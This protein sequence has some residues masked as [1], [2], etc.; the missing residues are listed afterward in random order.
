MLL[1]AASASASV[2]DIDGTI[3]TTDI[4]TQVDGLDIQSFCIDGETLIALEDLEPYGFTVYYNDNIR[5]VFITKTGTPND[6]FLPSVSRGKV[7]GTAGYYYETDIN[8]VVNGRIIRAYAVDGKMAA[9]VEDLGNTGRFSD[10]SRYTYHMSFDYDNSKRLLSLNTSLSQFGT[11]DDAK[12]VILDYRLWQ[13]NYCRIQHSGDKLLAEKH[14]GGLPHGGSQHNYYVSL[15]NGLIYDAS[16]IA[17]MY[18]INMNEPVFSA[19]GNYLYFKNTDLNGNFLDYKQLELNS[20]HIAPLT[21]ENYERAANR[22]AQ[23]DYVLV[24]N[25]TQL[26]LYTIGSTDYVKVSDLKERGCTAD[27]EKIR[28]INS[29]EYFPLYAWEYNHDNSLTY[30][31]CDYIQYNPYAKT[32]TARI[33]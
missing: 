1:G 18:Y 10:I 19:D 23:S 15:D 26:P 24:L 32:V 11:A 2:G 3:Y 30:T 6:D 12:Q 33:K 21:K 9:K 8:A 4:L 25:K 31:D 14:Y 13:P 28:T 16:Y 22:I 7:G 20:M 27:K 29:E 17:N 5:T